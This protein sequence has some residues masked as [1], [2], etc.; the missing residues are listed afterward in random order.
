MCFSYGSV[1]LPATIVDGYRGDELGERALSD[2][3][4]GHPARRWAIQIG[5][6]EAAG[7][8][9]PNYRVAGHDAADRAHATLIHKA[10][11]RDCAT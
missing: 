7:R 1:R 2:H 8:H 5:P 11:P 9:R 4:P 10:E 3:A 6:E